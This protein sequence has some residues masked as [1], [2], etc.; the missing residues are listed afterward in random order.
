MHCVLKKC[1]LVPVGLLDSAVSLDYFQL[2]KVTKISEDFRP[3][4]IRQIFQPYVF[5]YIY[6]HIYFNVRDLW[7]SRLQ[8]L[9]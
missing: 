1:F 7:D 5:E 9:P 4:I 2:F 3:C 6:L 8:S